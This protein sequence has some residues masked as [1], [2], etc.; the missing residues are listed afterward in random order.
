MLE[1]PQKWYIKLYRVKYSEGLFSVT[2][3]LIYMK[4]IENIFR[5][6]LQK[7]E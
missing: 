3:R 1:S 6:E 4:E 7:H 5:V 2:K